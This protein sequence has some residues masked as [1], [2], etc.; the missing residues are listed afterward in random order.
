M[1]RIVRHLS[2][3][4][5]IAL[6]VV[7]TFAKASAQNADKDSLEIQH[8]TLTMP[9]VTKFW[10]TF[11]SLAKVTKDRPELKDALETDTEKHEDLASIEKRISS[12]P[13]VQSAITDHGLTVHEFVLIQITLFQAVMASAIAPPGPDRAKK[14]AEANIN[15]A[16]LDFVDKHKAELEALQAK[17]VSKDAGSNQ[18]ANLAAHRRYAAC[19]FRL[20]RAALSPAIGASDPPQSECN[21]LAFARNAASISSREEPGRTPRISHGVLRVGNATKPVNACFTMD[22]K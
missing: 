21:R 17:N 9:A 11:G 8:Y 15:P 20:S 1:P 13:V 4:L 19:S 2:F 14:A 10:E 6:C 3:A 12:V 7:L 18:R 22:I 5:T 16:N